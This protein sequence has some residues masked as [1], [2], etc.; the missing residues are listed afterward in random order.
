MNREIKE[1]MVV[2]E[3]GLA[4]LQ[5]GVRAWMLSGWQPYGGVAVLGEQMLQAMVK[6]DTE[7]S[8]T[9]RAIV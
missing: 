6:Y 4:A 9:C 1:Y 3:W 8:D 5:G 7:D 2:Q